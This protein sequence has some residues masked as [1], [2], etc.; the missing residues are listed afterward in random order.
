MLNTIIFI[1]S[2]NTRLKTTLFWFRICFTTKN[3]IFMFAQW[4]NVWKKYMKANELKAT[5]MNLKYLNIC[6][7]H[8]NVVKLTDIRSLFY[9]CKS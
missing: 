4:D 6:K 1:K 5:D 3:T 9:S 2:R 8:N 7:F